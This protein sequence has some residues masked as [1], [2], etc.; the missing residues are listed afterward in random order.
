MKYWRGYL[1]AGIFA[2]I[3][4][5]LME[6]AKRY[7]ILVDMVYPYVTRS[8]QGFLTAWTGGFDFCV[9]QIV[10]LILGVLVLASLVLVLVFKGSIIQWTGWVLAVVSV[11]FCLNTGI[12]GLNYYAGP[13]E[14]DLRLEMHDYTQYE[15]EQAAVYYRDKANAIA[16]QLPRDE[17]GI[18]RYSTFEELAQRAGNGFRNLV[19]DRSF[20]IFGGD[21]TPVKAL[22]WAD[23]YTSMGI[24]GFT[25]FLTGEAAV[26]PQIPAI[27]QPFTICH[28]MAHRLCVARE[29]A[30]NFA[31]YLACEASASREYQYSGFF[32]AYR[33]CYTALYNVDPAAALRIRE[34]CVNELLWDLDYYSNFFSSHRDEE[35]TQLAD[36]VND[37]YLK[38]SGDEDGIASYGAV[39]DY[40]VNW[41]LAEFAAEEEKEYQFDP[42]DPEQVDLSGLPNYVPQET[43]SAA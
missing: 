32:M 1:T 9:W 25:C 24:T 35:A 42:F 21:Y 2:A 40:L 11:L 28:E 29:D 38:V 23:M 16:V 18:V 34:G 19:I 20:S 26:N 31:A 30:A 8:V 33:Y 10:V 14:D 37:T 7:G 3:T 12:Y 5:A 39:C 13:I 43:E 41:Y 4:W 22:G 17:T 27:T 6:C 15:L 36:T